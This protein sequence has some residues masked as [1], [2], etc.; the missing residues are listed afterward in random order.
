[1]GKKILVLG[2]EGMLG[3]ALSKIFIDYEITNCGR[4]ELDITNKKRVQEK[5]EQFK[6][7][8]VVN[9]AAYTDVDKCET[10]RDLAIKING[11]AVKH[12]AE[13]CNKI[14][15]FLI[16]IST[17]YVFNGRKKTGYSEN[18]RTNPINTYGE[19][20]LQGEMNLI[21]NSDNHYLIR[22]SWLF[23]FN[24]KNFVETIIRLS[25][26]KDEIFVVNDQIGS[27]TYTLDLAKKIKELIEKKYESGIYHI[28]NRGT[29]TW[30][31]F[32]KEIVRLS[33]NNCKINSVTTDDFPLPAKRPK[34]SILI[35][36]KIDKPLRH[37]KHAIKEYIVERNHA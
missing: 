9:A 21:T 1:M 28:T 18:D 30:Y 14:G 8:I 35:N 17:D 29:C 3:S 2:A 23:G 31:E 19:S 22:T 24:G 12:I 33:K 16:Y 5:L 36:T 13:V 7:E 15:A 34:C 27:P 20:K 10:N 4:S 11:D 25:K 37:W 6:P 32:A 26:E